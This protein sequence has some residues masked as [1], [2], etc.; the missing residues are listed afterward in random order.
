MS[1]LF[2]RSEVMEIILNCGGFAVFQVVQ[3]L[4]KTCLAATN[5]WLLP[6][7][8]ECP[9]NVQKICM[10]LDYEVQEHRFQRLLAAARED[11]PLMNLDTFQKV[12]LQLAFTSFRTSRGHPYVVTADEICELLLRSISHRLVSQHILS[13][14]VKNYLYDL[15]F[16]LGS[17]VGDRMQY[18]CF[19]WR[20]NCNDHLNL[21]T[22]MENVYSLA[23]LWRWLR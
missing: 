18:I 17:N 2:G 20:H 1:S 8:L 12:V 9:I 5:P 11:I 10:L 19:A 21:L 6:A 15:G 13:V 23:I 16:L 22:F 14:R 7:V 3:N 4:S